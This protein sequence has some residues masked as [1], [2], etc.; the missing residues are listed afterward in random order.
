ML[1]PPSGYPKKRGPIA[2]GMFN[3]ISTP[4]VGH[5]GCAVE[6]PGLG[7]QSGGTR[8]VRWISISH[9]MM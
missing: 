1:K 2:N 5:P 9:L 7:S 8:D 4:E 3:Q 6:I